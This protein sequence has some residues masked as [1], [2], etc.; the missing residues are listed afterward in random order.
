M[1]C[2]M[3]SEFH[4]LRLTEP[5]GLGIIGNANL[6]RTSFRIDLI[7]FVLV[8]GANVQDADRSENHTEVPLNTSLL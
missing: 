3:L 1:I 6:S 7:A 8:I 2:Y 5:L 4:G